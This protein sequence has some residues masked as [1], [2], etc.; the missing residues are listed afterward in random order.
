[1][2]KQIE[3]NPP[4]NEDFAAC[5]DCIHMEDTLEICIL[6][7]CVHAIGHLKECYVPRK[8]IKE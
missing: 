2:L 8:E 4:P 3:V 5:D 6:R 1:M 7:Q